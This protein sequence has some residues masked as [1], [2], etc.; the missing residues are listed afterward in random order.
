[1][2]KKNK[3]LL[4]ISYKDEM[5]RREKWTGIQKRIEGNAKEDN[6]GNEM[7]AVLRKMQIGP[8]E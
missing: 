3:K 1:M 7:Q 4:L 5:G 2:R 6:A 8:R